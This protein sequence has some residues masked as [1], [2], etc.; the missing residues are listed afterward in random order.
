MELESFKPD[1]RSEVPSFGI[2]RR[3]GERFP[4]T[5]NLRFRRVSKCENWTKGRSVNFSHTGILF[6]ADRP[7]H[8]G[9]SLELVVDWPADSGVVWKRELVLVGM[10][11]RVRDREVALSIRKF[12]FRSRASQD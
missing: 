9:A 11:I 10:V 7:T 5:L 2:D 12:A 8:L 4:L 3:R 6:R 1:V